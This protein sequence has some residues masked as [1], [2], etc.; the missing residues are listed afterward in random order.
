MGVLYFG[1]VTLSINKQAY[2]I[3]DIELLR[4]SKRLREVRKDS[5]K[6][7]VLHSVV[8]GDIIGVA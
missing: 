6:A 7:A 2:G 1:E 8:K 5:G 3:A 4:K